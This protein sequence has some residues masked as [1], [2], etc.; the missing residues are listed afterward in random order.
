MIA[1]TFYLALV[2]KVYLIVLLGLDDDFFYTVYLEDYFLAL[3][4]DVYLGC[5]FERSQARTDRD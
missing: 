3:N 1:T 2:L 4:R 5:R